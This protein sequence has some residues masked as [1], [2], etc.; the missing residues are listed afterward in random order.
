[1][2][3]IQNH[4]DR[5]RILLVD[6]NEIDAFILKALLSDSGISSNL[7]H[8]SD[9]FAALSVL[10]E[11]PEHKLSAEHFFIFLDLHM[12]LLNGIEF[13]Y[14]LQKLNPLSIERV[15]ILSS[16]YVEIQQKLI[17]NFPVAG[18]ISKPLS[19]ENFKQ[20]FKDSNLSSLDAE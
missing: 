20:L 9:P 13:L 11:V 15:Y 7:E 6:D 1:M 18:F 4:A 2:P 12:P 17:G 3:T 10:A 16:E 5:K 14:K 19:L 8:Y